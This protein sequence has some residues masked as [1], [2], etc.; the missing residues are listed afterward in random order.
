MTTRIMSR[1]K[2]CPGARETWFRPKAGLGNLRIISSSDLPRMEIRG[3]QYGCR[4][5]SRSVRFGPAAGVLYCSA[6]EDCGKADFRTTKACRRP[7][8]PGPRTCPGH[9]PGRKV[10]LSCPESNSICL[11]LNSICHDSNSIRH[12]LNSSCH[13]S[14]SICC[15]SNSSCLN[16]NSIRLDLNSICDDGNSIRHDFNSIRDDSNS[17][18]HDSNSLGHE[19]NR[20]CL[21]SNRLCHDSD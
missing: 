10:N 7:V 13:D 19:V 16:S 6:D 11:N 14:N 2:A 20:L 5:T 9:P 1:A 3:S 17:I 21:N 18:C 12:D 4:D 8:R 15:N